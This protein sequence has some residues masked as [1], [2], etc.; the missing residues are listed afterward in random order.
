MQTYAL[1]MPSVQNHLQ[2]E[3]GFD[4]TLKLD[5]E[6]SGLYIDNVLPPPVYYLWFLA[7]TYTQKCD[8]FVVCTLHAIMLLV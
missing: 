2:A 5:S 4:F 6:P 3:H 8:W 7:K 1:L